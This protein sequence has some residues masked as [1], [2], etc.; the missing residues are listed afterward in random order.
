MPEPAYRPEEIM[1]AGLFNRIKN[2]VR[3][4]RGQQ[5]TNKAREMAKDPRNRERARKAAQKLR[6]KR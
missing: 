3:S 6:R 2:F 5:L 1:M 4:P